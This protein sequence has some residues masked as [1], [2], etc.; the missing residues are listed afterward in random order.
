MQKHKE[1]VKFG[2]LDYAPKEIMMRAETKEEQ[3]RLDSCLKE[4]GTVK[5]LEGAVKTDDIVY[6]VG[7]SVGAYTLVAGHLLGDSGRCYA[8]EPA[9][10]SMSTL[11]VNISVNN[12]VNKCIPICIAFADVE[13]I[14]FL[15]LSSMHPGAASH[16]L[17][18]EKHPQPI[19]LIPM[20]T[21]IERYKIPVPNL[22]KIDVDKNE[23]PVLKGAPKTLRNP[24]LREVLVEVDER[25]D[26][27]RRFIEQEMFQA[28]FKIKEKHKIM[29]SLEDDVWNRLYVRREQ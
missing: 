5:W 28:G 2:K 14:K 21:F 25:Q 10:P 6:D 24:R 22:I 15:A 7:A 20:D 27:D 16:G 18:Q 26:A 8:F 12:M 13:E 17:H 11:F 23:V 9:T 1:D 3:K 4:P 19:V 29:S